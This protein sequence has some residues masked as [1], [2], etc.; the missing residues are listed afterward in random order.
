MPDNRRNH[1]RYN[2]QAKV[3]VT[4]NDVILHGTECVNISSGG[5]CIKVGDRIDAIDKGMLIMIHKYQNEVIFFKSDFSVSW[6]SIQSP[7][8]YNAQIGIVFKK[9]D[10]DNKNALDRILSFQTNVHN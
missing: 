10:S 8:R 9:L 2:F 4:M 3:T 1:E 6:N 7:V 5:M